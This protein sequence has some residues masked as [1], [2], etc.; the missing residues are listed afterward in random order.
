M[1]K[2][3]H[4]R[5]RI[6]ST[7]VGDDAAFGSVVPPLYLSANYVWSDP[8]EKPQYD[9]SRC[10][11]PTRTQLAKALCQLEGA[12]S[13]V[14][15]NSGMAAID[16]VLNLVGPGDLVL[17]PHDCYGGTHRLLSAR[18]KQRQ[19]DLAFVDQSDLAAFTVAIAAKPK[20]IL[21]ETPSNPLLRI[22]DIRACVVLAK[23]CGAIVVADN[24]FLS[25]A[26]QRPLELGCD[27]VVHST[28]KFINGHSDVVGGAVLAGDKALGEELS[29]WANCTGVT[30]AAFDSYLTLRGLRTLFTRMQRQQQTAVFVV[31]ALVQ[32]ARVARVFYPGLHDHPGHKLARS[33]QDGFGS[34]FSVEFATSIDVLALLRELQ[35]FTI[36]ESLGGFESLVCAPAIMTHAAMTAKARKTAGISERLVRFSIGLEHENDLLRD[37]LDALDRLVA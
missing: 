9:Y 11:N 19:F 27:V 8:C 10:G 30:G 20:L 24:T 17:A 36:A 14:I 35:V 22:T 4:P 3:F 6:A 33:Q 1:T 31:D 12:Q 21:I 5:T 26:L 25:P 32:D 13:G 37:V 16:L 28:T 7:G 23:T 2:Q 18:A 29:W 15:T 34:M